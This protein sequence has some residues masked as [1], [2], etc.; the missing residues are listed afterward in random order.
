MGRFLIEAL[1]VIDADG[2]LLTQGGTGNYAMG[3]TAAQARSRAVVITG[4]SWRWLHERGY[5]VV[6]ARL[7]RKS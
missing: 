3:A 2:D 4:R 5:R 6:T 1:V 7:E